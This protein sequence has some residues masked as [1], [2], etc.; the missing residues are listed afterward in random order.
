MAK[1]ISEDNVFY[2]KLVTNREFDIQK[3]KSGDEKYNRERQP[4]NTVTIEDLITSLKTKKLRL[5]DIE[6]VHFVET[7]PKTN[8]MNYTEEFKE[9][10]SNIK[11]RQLLKEIYVE[12]DKPYTPQMLHK[13]LKEVYTTIFNILITVVS[14]VVACWY[15][16]PFMDINLRVLLAL[17]VGMLVLVADVVVYNSFKKNQIKLH[18]IKK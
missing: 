13:E 4:S 16:T 9:S 17:F 11:K 3:L 18:I 5:K 1:D 7:K 2:M 14:S 10:L 6:D 8:G 12:E 15:W